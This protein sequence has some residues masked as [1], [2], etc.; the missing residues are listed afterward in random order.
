MEADTAKALR[1]EGSWLYALIVEE[2]PVDAGNVTFTVRPW[3]ER[4]GRQIAGPVYTVVCSGAGIVSV[5]L[6]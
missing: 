6:S 3:C 5:T 2:I 4:D 1:G